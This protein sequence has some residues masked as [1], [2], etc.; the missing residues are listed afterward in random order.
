M[1]TVVPIWALVLGTG[2]T[3]A[4]KWAPWCPK[5]SYGHQPNLVTH[6]VCLQVQ[7]CLTYRL[8]FCDSFQ[9][10]LTGC[11]S[12]LDVVTVSRVGA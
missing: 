8:N 12:V 7:V 5:N 1:G 4:Q 6:S 2:G 3:G 9:L 10:Q 11:F